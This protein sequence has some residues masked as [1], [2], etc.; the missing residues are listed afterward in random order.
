M[1]NFNNNNYYPEDEW[2]RISTP[3]IK[4]TD[5]ENHQFS[6]GDEAVS[7]V[8]KPNKH[9][10]L[11]FQLIVVLVALLFI[12]AVKFLGLPLYSSVISWYNKEIS[13]SVI[14]NGNFESFDFSSV[15]STEDEA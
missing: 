14:Y 12:F 6:D 7:K 15:F 5:D 13:K 9:P 11:S 8:K 3:M 2:Q 1:D 10:V 4:S